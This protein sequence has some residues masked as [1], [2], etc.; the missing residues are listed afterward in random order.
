MS[1][2]LPVSRFAP[3]FTL[4]MIV[5]LAAQTT[6]GRTNVTPAAKRQTTNATPRTADGHPDLQ[7]VWTNATLTPMERPAAFAGKATATDDEAAKWE[8]AQTDEVAAADGKA[9]ADFPASLRR[10]RIGKE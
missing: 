1:R 5:P 3:L 8:K 4:V 7:G 9:D 2:R 10:S 6:P